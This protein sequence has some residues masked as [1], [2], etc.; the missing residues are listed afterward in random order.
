MLEHDIQNQIRFAISKSRLA[1]CFRANVGEAWTGEEK[2][3]RDGSITISEPRR[4]QT[5]L[6][7]GFSDLF[8]VV[9]V[10]ITPDM[11]GQTVARVA[12]VEVKT[13]RGR[14]SPAQKNFLEQMSALGAL[15]GVARSPEDAIKI[16]K[17]KG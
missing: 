1:T 7:K 10:T 5:G 9:P 3:N 6:P 12:F 17:G 16:L 8:C 4:L 15:T 11:V 13:E 14:L 2:R